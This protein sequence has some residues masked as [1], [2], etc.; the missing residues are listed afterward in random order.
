MQRQWRV[1]QMAKDGAEAGQRTQAG[2]FG[3]HFTAQKALE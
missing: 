3:A 1:F 2:A